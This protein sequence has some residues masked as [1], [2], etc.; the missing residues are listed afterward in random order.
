M[1][2][3]DTQAD[4]ISVF[5]WWVAPGEAEALQGLVD[6]YK[7]VHPETRVLFDDDA[8][9]GTWRDKV[10]AQIEDSPWDIVQMSASDLE[11]FVEANPGMLSPLDEIYD[12][13]SLKAA[14]I[15]EIGEAVL[16]KG[17][18]MG[19]VTGVH[20]NNSFF[21]NQR[22]LD[23]EE[24]AP[25]TT[26]DEFLE[27]CATLK[28]AGI[29]PVA[30][31]FQSWALRIMFDGLLAGT[32]GAEE[33]SSF[34]ESGAPPASDDVKADIESAIDAFDLVLTEYVDISLSK[35]A[36]YG[37]AEATTSFQDGDAALMFHGDWAKGYLV[38]LGSSP[39]IDF[40]VTGP[41]GA[42]DLFIYGA[43]TFVMPTTAPHK[44]KALEFLSVVASQDGQATF[45]RFKG[46][47]P[48]RSDVR[49]D[50]DEPGKANLDSLVNAQVLMKGH[51]NS[52]WDAAIEAYAMDGDKAALLE[53]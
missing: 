44:D 10:E 47:T 25:P 38:S 50:L 11:D 22:I 21:F 51:P 13:P 30:V 45:S 46:S 27:A 14:L 3:D 8:D 16:V 49:G 7:D 2:G 37:W 26:V 42:E 29:T 15:P 1:G 23:A 33:F 9:A 31:T 52:E 19:V 48:M 53:V 5:S 28:A 17:K 39:G 20:R 40:G 6:T 4:E 12:E 41:P 32:M 35:G 34:L 18:A 36:D 43:D 24:I